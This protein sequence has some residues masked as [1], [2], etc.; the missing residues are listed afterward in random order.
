[1]L[2]QFP[3]KF[4]KMYSNM[5]DLLQLLD[6]DD[7]KESDN[8]ELRDDTELT[9]HEVSCHAAVVFTLSL[10]QVSSVQK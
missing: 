10:N 1:M 7:I 8:I 9:I 4:I 3:Y 6:L 2:K 5:N